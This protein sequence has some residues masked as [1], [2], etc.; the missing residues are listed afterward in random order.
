MRTI[1]I[2]FLIFLLVLMS[3]RGNAETH[4]LDLAESIAIAKM[5]SFDMLSLKQD[6]KIAE[7]NLK[8]ATSRFKTH[9]DLDLDVPNYTETYQQDEDSS[10]IT[11]FRKQQ[12]ELSSV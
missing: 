8:S 2:S 3:F 5:K 9:V 7:Y 4:Q 6:L 10:G 11:Y 1:Q 12:S